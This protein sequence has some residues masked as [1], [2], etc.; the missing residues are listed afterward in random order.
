MTVTCGCFG[1]SARPYSE[2]RTL[3]ARGRSAPDP[4]Q[5]SM[6][7]LSAMEVARTEVPLVARTLTADSALILCLVALAPLAGCAASPGD[8]ANAAD[9]GASTNS[10]SSSGSTPGGSSG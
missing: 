10:G 2:T 6:G 8:D 5:L 7:T 4:A 9:G 1:V 3:F